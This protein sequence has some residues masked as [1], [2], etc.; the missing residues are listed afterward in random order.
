LR[1]HAN[2]ASTSS[3]A[4]RVATVVSAMAVIASPDHGLGAG[5]DSA[6]V[7]SDAAPPLGT[8]S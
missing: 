6:T 7:E 5:R 2:T 3:P 4:R 8:P 1:E